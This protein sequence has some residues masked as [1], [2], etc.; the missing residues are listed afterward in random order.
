MPVNTGN[1]SRQKRLAESILVPNIF[2]I[3][4]A[5]PGNTS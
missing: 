3:Q 4:L 5:I 2:L 1:F